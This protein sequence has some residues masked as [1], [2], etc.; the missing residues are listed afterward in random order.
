MAILLL[1]F[2]VQPSLREHRP[3]RNGAPEELPFGE[4][5][6]HLQIAAQNLLYQGELHA[7]FYY[8]LTDRPE[9]HKNV[10]PRTALLV[11][12]KPAGYLPDR[13]AC[14]RAEKADPGEQRLD[15]V[16]PGGVKQPGYPGKLGSRSHTDEY[17]FA[18]QVVAVAGC[19]LQGMA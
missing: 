7:L 18:M 17:R 8:R 5:G 15:S 12:K 4:R 14:R 2:P 1:F 13:E 6:P 19:R 10:F 16:S 9:K 3:P 11:V